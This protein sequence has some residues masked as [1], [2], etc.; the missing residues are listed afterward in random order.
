M[1]VI[2]EG[3][4]RKIRKLLIPQPDR[5]LAMHSSNP[6]ALAEVVDVKQFE[7]K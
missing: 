3:L 4:S 7:D 6:P 5:V 2:A 1:T